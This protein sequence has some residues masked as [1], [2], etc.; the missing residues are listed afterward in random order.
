MTG[1]T[2]PEVDCKHPNCA[3]K[4][5]SKQ[6]MGRHYQKRHV[7]S[8]SYACDACGERFFRKLQ[9]RMHQ[10]CHTVVH[11]HRCDDCGQRFVNL[12]LKRK[13]RRELCDK[14]INDMRNLNLHACV[15][16]QQ[17]KEKRV[18][19]TSIFYVCPYESCFRLHQ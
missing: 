1:N 12:Q 5:T 6:A 11:P 15:V 4:F 18:K 13:H 10:R 3:L 14:L 19:Q 9:L 17:R 8:K 7:L 16:L 2:R